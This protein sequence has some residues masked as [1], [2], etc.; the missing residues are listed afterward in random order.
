MQ[1]WN[2]AASFT[3]PSNTTAYAS[4]NLV[5][6]SVTS[7]SVVPLAFA[8]GNSYGIGQFRI[9]RARLAKSGTGVTNASFRIHLYA[10]QP[11]PANRHGRARSPAQPPHGVV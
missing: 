4:G 8:L 3:R 7:G 5:A 1:I 9:N 6:N 11:T 2:P 10:P